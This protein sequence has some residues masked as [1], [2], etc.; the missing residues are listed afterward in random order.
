MTFHYAM[1]VVSLREPIHALHLHMATG[2]VDQV[3]S[4]RVI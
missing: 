4:D 3:Q 1:K 2:D